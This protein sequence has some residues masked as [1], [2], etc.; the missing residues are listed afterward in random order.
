MVLLTQ[1]Y[2]QQLIISIYL[3]MNEKIISSNFGGIIETSLISSVVSN[4]L[5]YCYVFLFGT[6]TYQRKRLYRLVINGET[7]IVEKA[8]RRLKRTMNFSI[9]L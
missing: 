5:V 6:S 7:L 2:T 9:I 1:V 3:T 4:L 8:W